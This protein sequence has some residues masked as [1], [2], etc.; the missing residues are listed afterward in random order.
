MGDVDP[1]HP[2]NTIAYNDLDGVTVQ[3]GIGNPIVRNSIF[4][5]G[6]LGIDLDD[7]GISPNDPA[8]DADAGGND[9]QNTPVI[10]SATPNTISWTL[11]SL[12]L[13]TFR[14]E[15]YSDPQCDSKHAAEGRRFLG[16]TEVVTD[17]KG[18]A[19][20]VIAPSVLLRPPVNVVASAT[21]VQDGVLVETSEFSPCVAVA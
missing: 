6:G 7:D 11:A 15:F 16:S 2:M 12:P 5:N 13:H 3:D 20:G 1:A 14:I 9:L 8:P 18:L 4:L 19:A 21:V 17:A 10:V